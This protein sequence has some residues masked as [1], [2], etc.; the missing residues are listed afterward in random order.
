[1]QFR[2]LLIHLKGVLGAHQLPLDVHAHE[3]RML[4]AAE[5]LHEQLTKGLIKAIYKANR[6]SNL[7]GAISRDKT[8][9]VLVAARAQIQAAK[10]TDIDTFHYMED[11]CHA[12]HAF[13]LQHEQPQP[14]EAEAE[15]TETGTAKLLRMPTRPRRR[16]GPTHK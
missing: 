12:V 13:F 4:Y 2:A 6:C 10:R 1:M 5:P 7:D 15:G 9:Q 14:A 16:A 8:E 3:L 11:L